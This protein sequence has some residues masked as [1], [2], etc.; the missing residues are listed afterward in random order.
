METPTVATFV[1]AY[2]D[3]MCP[4]PTLLLLTMVTLLSCQRPQLQPEPAQYSV[5]AE[6]EP[7]VQHFRDELKNRGQTPATNNLVITFGPTQGND[8]CGQCL[9][10]SGKT[11]RI[12]IN[13]N[14]FC[15]RSANEYERECLVFHELG[16]CLLNR[17]H[18]SSR[19]P[20]N[21]YVSLMNPDDRAVYAP[22][23]YPVGN[24]ECDKRPRRAYY[25]DELA[26]ST[27]SAPI[28][29]K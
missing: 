10:E 3:P 23:A 25:L 12:I 9:L 5:P 16:H 13:S 1:T 26:D 24:D 28:W 21:A 19:F 4:A 15:W 6:V 11:P 22:C 8:I 27:T 7:Y 29:A 17:G 2:A 18:R 14:A 20:N